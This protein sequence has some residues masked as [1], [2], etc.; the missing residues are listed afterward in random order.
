MAAATG[1]VAS[2]AGV[3]VALAAAFPS[4]NLTMLVCWADLQ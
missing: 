4:N 2:A 3:V 1:A